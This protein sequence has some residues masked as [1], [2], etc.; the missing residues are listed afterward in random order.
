MPAAARQIILSRA[1]HNL[2]ANSVWAGGPP[3]TGWTQ[4]FGTGTLSAV[5]SAFPDHT[6]MRFEGTGERPVLQYS[7]VPV[8][9]GQ[10]VTIAFDVEAITD[11]IR[12]D[13]LVSIA[14]AA[15]TFVYP[16]GAPSSTLLTAPGRYRFV[17]Y[18]TTGGNMIVRI[19]LGAQN[20]ATGDITISRPQV[21]R[22]A[23]VANYRLTKG[24]AIL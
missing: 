18:I 11:G 3:P 8:V 15:G 21:Y 4:P 6:A 24:T 22:G 9:V 5:A 10:V 23:G 14:T 12:Y 1:G 2:V 19:G 17:V 7:S 20:V 16:G 13:L